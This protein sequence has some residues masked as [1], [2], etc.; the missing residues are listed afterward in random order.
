MQEHW[1]FFVNKRVI[2]EAR[3]TMNHFK[4]KVGY[5]PATNLFTYNHVRCQPY[6]NHNSFYLKTPFI[7][8]S[9]YRKLLLLQIPFAVASIQKL[10]TPDSSVNR[11][12][13]PPASAGIT[14]VGQLSR[15]VIECSQ[16]HA[17][18][19]IPGTARWNPTSVINLAIVSTCIDIGHYARICEVIEPGLHALIR[20]IVYRPISH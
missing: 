7:K 1:N 20:N 17:V 2:S 11:T 15:F 10:F 18:E 19:G 8:R 4:K 16:R 9:I 14:Q 3:E 6:L 5:L 13:V 12:A